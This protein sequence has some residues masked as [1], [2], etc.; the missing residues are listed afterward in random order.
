MKDYSFGVIPIYKKDSEV[1]FL[2][3]CHNAGH[4]SFPKGHKENDE[5]DIEVAMRELREETGITK[6]QLLTDQQ[7][8][9]RYSWTRE[10]TVV[11]KT[12]KYFV[13]LVDTKVA[14]IQKSEIQDYR[15]VNYDDALKLATY[16]EAQK[17]IK[18]VYG[19]VK[20]YLP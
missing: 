20:N 9:E 14:K 1:C 7:F 6:C 4:W 10:D 19:S 8:I 13:G 17:I 2:M 3:I 16:S 5:S 15:W 18:E 11:D 12:V